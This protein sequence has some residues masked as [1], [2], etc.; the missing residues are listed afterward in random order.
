ME[1]GV[2]QDLR[3]CNGQTSADR[4][5]DPRSD[6]APMIVEHLPQCRFKLLVDDFDSTVQGLDQ[7]MAYLEEED[8]DPLDVNASDQGGAG[9]DLQSLLNDPDLNAELQALEL[10]EQNV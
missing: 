4:P 2:L 1:L 7:T 6:I 5:L 3:S 9:D 8:A 10:E